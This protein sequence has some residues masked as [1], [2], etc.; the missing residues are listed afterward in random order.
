MSMRRCG[1][2]VTIEQVRVGEVLGGVQR[3]WEGEGVKG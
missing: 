1:G 2:E 3:E